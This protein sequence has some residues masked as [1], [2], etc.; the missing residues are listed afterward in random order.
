MLRGREM[1]VVV[2]WGWVSRLGS[3]LSEAGGLLKTLGR[4]DWE[5][6][7]FCNINKYNSLMFLKRS[8]FYYIVILIT[9]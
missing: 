2:R 7:D 9:Y 8:I 5:Q 1:V 3:T 6:G 4:G